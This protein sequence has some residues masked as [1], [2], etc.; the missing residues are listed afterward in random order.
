M[1]SGT[2]GIA[3][4]RMRTHN[5]RAS[6][7]TG[8]GRRWNWVP[9]QGEEGEGRKWDEGKSLLRSRNFCVAVEWREDSIVSRSRECHATRETLLPHQKK[10]EY[11]LT[12]S[13]SS[14]MTSQRQQPIYTPNLHYHRSIDDD[15]HRRCARHAHSLIIP[16]LV[17]VS[18]LEAYRG[19]SGG[20]SLSSSG[21]SGGG[22]RS[23]GGPRRERGWYHREAA[24]LLVERWEKRWRGVGRGNGVLSAAVGGINAQGTLFPAAAASIGCCCRR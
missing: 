7:V 13:R 20:G 21:G 18:R 9:G 4:L 10:K 12:V 16:V 14:I 15:G 3:H 2:G 24:A 19:R 23:G 6:R 1:E 11:M 22:G 5:T 8:S 17:T